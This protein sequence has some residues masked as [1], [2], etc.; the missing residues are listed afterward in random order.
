MLRCPHVYAAFSGNI[1]A[2]G[3][4]G[5]HQAF[6]QSEDHGTQGIGCLLY[7]AVPVELLQ[8]LGSPDAFSAAVDEKHQKVQHL[9][10]ETLSQK[11]R[12]PLIG[13]AESSK[14]LYVNDIRI[15]L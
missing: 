12:L 14:H 10:A 4:A 15:I 6:S 5:C 11:K 13:H 2:I 9:T 3:K 7:V 8:Q 1:L